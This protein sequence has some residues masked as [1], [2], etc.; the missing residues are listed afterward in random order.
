MSAEPVDA[1]AAANPPHAIAEATNN[2]AA[3]AA[4]AS[5]RNMMIIGAIVVV[6]IIVII[7]VTVVMTNKKKEEDAKAA[8]AKAAAKPP[9]APPAPP[10]DVKPPGSTAPVSTA[11]KPKEA[12]PVA[13]A[14]AAPQTQAAAGPWKCVK[15]YNAPMRKDTKGDVQ[16]MSNNHKDCTWKESPDQCQAVAATPVVPLDPLT[17]GDGHKAAWGSPGYD[18]PDHWCSKVKQ[19][20]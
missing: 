9:A 15:G 17:C 18:N 13:S 11:P 5:K 1:L 12:T 19:L 10:A 20:I 16:C 2:V 8:A 6:V 7:V 4:N 3:N 14:P